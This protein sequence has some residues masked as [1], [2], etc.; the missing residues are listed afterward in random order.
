MTNRKWL[1]ALI[2][3]SSIACLYGA[4]PSPA[5]SLSGLKYRLQVLPNLEGYVRSP[6]RGLGV[7]EGE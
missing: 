6:A 7:T 3:G 1:A 2:L 5:Q 4:D